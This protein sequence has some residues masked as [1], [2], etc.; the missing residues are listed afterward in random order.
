MDGY[1][2]L[3]VTV[4]GVVGFLVFWLTTSSVSNLTDRV[5]RLEDELG[6]GEK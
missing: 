2:A 1:V 5:K 3:A 6:V 4:L